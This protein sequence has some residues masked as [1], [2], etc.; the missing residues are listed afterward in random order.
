MISFQSTIQAIH[1]RMITDQ[2]LSASDIEEI[3]RQVSLTS[4]QTMSTTPAQFIIK[5]VYISN[6]LA[7]QI[8]IPLVDN[9]KQAT[10]F[11]VYKFPSF[12]DGRKLVPNCGDQYIAVYDNSNSYNILSPAEYDQ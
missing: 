11:Q 2:L 4:S 8:E 9:A 7:V 6:A 1:Y 3:S 5:P 12:Q 10:L